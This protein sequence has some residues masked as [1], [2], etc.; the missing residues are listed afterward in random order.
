MSKE[1]GGIQSPFDNAIC[2]VPSA[3]GG[4]GVKDVGGVSIP[5]GMK[6]TTGEMPEVSGVNLPDAKAPG[7]SR[8][9]DMS[10]S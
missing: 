4:D 1:F 2:P 7:T 5:D 10:G 6:G 3:G 9:P 8:P